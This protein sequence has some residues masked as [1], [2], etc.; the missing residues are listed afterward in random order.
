MAVEYNLYRPGT[1]PLFFRLP[2][3][4]GVRLGPVK[5]PPSDHHAPRRQSAIYG[6][7][8]MISPFVIK[9][10]TNRPI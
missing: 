3:G 7:R 1:L 8:A 5:L 4:W 10:P 2:R 6:R 9:N